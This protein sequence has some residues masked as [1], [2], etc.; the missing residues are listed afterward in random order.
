MCW[1]CEASVRRSWLQPG[2]PMWSYKAVASHTLHT[3]ILGP[4]LI[5]ISRWDPTF[6]D[7]EGIHAPSESR[8][9]SL[10]RSKEGRVR[11]KG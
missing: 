8:N 6:P 1:L 11:Q 9:G 5:L 7:N 3:G 4:P 10:P 2:W